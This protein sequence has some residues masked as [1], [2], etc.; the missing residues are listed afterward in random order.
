MWYRFIIDCSSCSILSRLCSHTHNYFFAEFCSNATFRR[1]FIRLMH[2]WMCHVVPGCLSKC[3]ADKMKGPGQRSR[4]SDWLRNGR[5][6]GRSSSPDRVKN[7]RFSTSSRPA[8]G[9]TQP[10]IQW[11]PWAHS[12]EVKR[13]EREADHS[14]SASAEVKKMWI[15]TSTPPYAFIAYFFFYFYTYNINYK[16]TEIGNK[17]TTIYLIVG[18]ELLTTMVM[19]RCI[20]QDI[21]LRSPLKVNRR[22]GGTYEIDIQGRIIS[23]R[24]NEQEVAS[25]LA[26][27]ST[28]KMWGDTFLRN[29]A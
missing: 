29:V 24:R 14:P 12:R 16:L 10:P 13:Q 5:Q 28:L 4:H 1:P 27:S 21:W 3:W 6:R 7:F 17:I 18:F 8:L 22:F 25:Y 9:S 11:V 2:S 19:E 26:Y 20:F 23:Q 15:Y